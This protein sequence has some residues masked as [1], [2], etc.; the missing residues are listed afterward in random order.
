MQFAKLAELKVYADY[1]T[2]LKKQ[3][4]KA[5]AA[6]LPFRFYRGFDFD[7]GEK[8]MLLIG[9]LTATLAG[10]LKAQAATATPRA[11]G[12]CKVAGDSLEFETEKGSA[13]D[14]ELARALSQAGIT[15]VPVL[16]AKLSGD[17]GTKARTLESGAATQ[18]LA[19]LRVR[20]QKGAAG[21][22]EQARLIAAA[23]EKLAP[24]G[25]PQGGE[26]TIAE[27]VD[28]IEQGIVA[29]ERKDAIA[30]SAALAA[31]EAALGSNDG[32][33]AQREARL[34]QANQAVDAK[35]QGA[36]P[37][38]EP[39]LLADHPEY[40]A[41]LRTVGDLTALIVK[42]TAWHDAE[43][44]TQ[45]DA[46]RKI[47]AAQALVAEVEQKIALVRAD[48]AK[49][50]TKIDELDTKVKAATQF[51]QGAKKKA[52]K[53]IAAERQRIARLEAQIEK[54][55]KD[56]A[57]G[58]LQTLVR[59]ANKHGSARHGAQTGLEG[60]ALRAATGGRTPDQ[61]DN[62]HGVSRPRPDL[63]AEVDRRV[64]ALSDR[65]DPLRPAG[66]AA[67]LAMDAVLQEIAAL[68]AK[69]AADKAVTADTDAEADHGGKIEALLLDLE[70]KLAAAEG[71][72]PPADRTT[73]LASVKWN[74][75]TVQYVDDA[76]QPG[77]KRKVVN[78]DE[79][80]K[81]IVYQ[82]REARTKAA[83]MFLNHMLEKEAVERAI[84]VVQK[85]CTWTEYLDGTTWKTLDTVTV[86]LGK[87]RSAAGWGYG[88]VRNLDEKKVLNDA[89]K[90][91]ERF[92]DGQIDAA[93]LLQGLDVSFVTDADGSVPLVRNV[94]V[95]LQKMGGAWSSIT[96][97]P[98]ATDEP[99][100]SIT[101]K[102]V[103]SD[104]K[105][106]VGKPAPAPKGVG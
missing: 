16:V 73:P 35:V 91:L 106:T 85:Q 25:Q 69:I 61:A 26:D 95:T 18:R 92:R 28:R 70:K 56:P 3:A 42:A 39:G 10:E 23:I 54:L 74:K 52:E 77:G 63:L 89:N 99:G 27:Q 15:A 62:P 2:E 79:V 80:L 96:H 38:E 32:Q 44:K 6:V 90:V 55:Q 30:R 21:A 34:A 29:I 50:N 76:S 5:R 98:S 81:A 82:T 37:A 102:T 88:V 57:Y 53:D 36:R 7:A 105:D 12:L 48:I 24:G 93:G 45:Q 4:V 65:V 84:D 49:C 83:S 59:Q 97:F 71:S 67:V 14:T 104:A 86:V 103:R 87:P 40:Q 101:G 60:Q 47:P 58:K 68:R 22:P 8:P 20:L 94:R 13:N 1:K 33:D 66:G 9:K 41:A 31:D 75:V 17:A 72:P 64:K 46:E 78:R 19:A 100:W 11:Q 51:T 43:I